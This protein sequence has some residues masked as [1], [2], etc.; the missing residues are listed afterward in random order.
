MSDS[1]TILS[2]F[3]CVLLR[4]YLYPS[5][6]LKLCGMASH[7]SGINNAWMRPFPRQVL[8]ITLSYNNIGKRR[9][10]SYLKEILFIHY[11]YVQYIIK[12]DFCI[13]NLEYTARFIY[14]CHHTCCF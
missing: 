1:S 2:C 14:A 11:I 6:D 8:R 12:L 10:T 13:D 5:A 7:I 9:I 4:K 3:F